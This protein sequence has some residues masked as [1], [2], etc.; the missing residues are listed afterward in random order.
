MKYTGTRYKE[1]ESKINKYKIKQITIKTIIIVVAAVLASVGLFLLF[2]EYHPNEVKSENIAEST[3]IAITVATELAQKPI[4]KSTQPTTAKSV[5]TQVNKTW[6]FDI[7]D[8][9]CDYSAEA[10]VLTEDDRELVARIVM[11]EFGDGGYEACCLQAQAF[12]DGMIFSNLSVENTYHQFQYDAYSLDKTPNKDCYKAVDYIFAGNI[13]V[14][15]RII[16]MYD[17]NYCSSAWHE[18]QN[19]VIEYKGIRFFD[20]K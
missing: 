10:I 6:L 11:N 2:F 3:S 9:D 13:V 17:T 5:E 19:F 18:T 15:H 14:P 12:R 16:Y 8:P 7:D 20:A 1:K 4:E